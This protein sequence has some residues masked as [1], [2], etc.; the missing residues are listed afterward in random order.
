LNFHINSPQTGPIFLALAPFTP[1]L[2]QWYNLQVTRKNDTYTI[3]VNGTAVSSQPDSHRVPD[4]KAPLTIGE[5]ESPPG[6]FFMNGSLDEVA[7]YDNAVS[8]T[9]AAGQPASALSLA[10][11]ASSLLGTGQ[12]ALPA[13]P[14]AGPATP[15]APPA[16][17]SSPRPVSNVS[18]P[19][20]AGATDAV[21]AASY[22]A[23]NDD[24]AWLSAP[25]SSGLNA[26]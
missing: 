15:T 21:F 24:S 11:L 26:I 7:I 1:A 20:H 9:A 2:G 6:N 5:A 8:P 19:P 3:F 18:S 23:T 14:L 25:L 17:Q 16:S 13:A 12:P 10:P 22:T 4:A